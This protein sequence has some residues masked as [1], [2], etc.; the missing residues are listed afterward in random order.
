MV[1]TSYLAPSKQLSINLGE[2]V[3]TEFAFPE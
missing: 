1:L 3:S 2:M